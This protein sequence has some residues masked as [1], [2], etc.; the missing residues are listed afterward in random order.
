MMMNRLSWLLLLALAPL[1]CA[2][3]EEET[4]STTPPAQV[5]AAALKR[6]A[7]T[8]WTPPLPGTSMPL[9]NHMASISAVVE[10]KVKFILPAFTG[11]AAHEGK[12]I[13]P[14]DVIIQLDDTIAQANRAK[15]AAQ[16]KQAD[17]AVTAAQEELGRVKKLLMPM[18]GMQE[19]ALPL[20]NQVEL[21]KA[22]L[23]LQD[24][25][26][27]EK[28]AAAE[29]NALDQQLA[30]YKLRSPIA[31]RLGMIRAMPGQLL[32][33]GTT[34]AEVVSL[35]KIDVLCWVAPDTAAL[36][37]KKQSARIVMQDAANGDQPVASSG[38]V[39]FIDSQGQA[40]TGM[41]GV[42]VRFDNP[43]WRIRANA[44][45]RIQVC[46]KTK[47][48]ALACPEIALGTDEDPP[49]VIQVV[50]GK[51]KQG[52]AR[53]EARKLQA[54]IGVR[55]R[56]QGLVELV[57]LRDPESGKDVPL[58]DDMQFVVE[59][60]TGLETGDVV[61]LPKEEHEKEK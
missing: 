52:K 17:V 30:Y 26:A 7:L 2:R 59:G 32:T 19:S 45:L 50:E 51:D 34:V 13:K 1:A 61:E 14:D 12:E 58:R 16:K 6:A 44:I 22:R 11:E 38:N 20:S 55:D 53:L 28:A 27:K 35:E 42:K 39:V 43:D 60:G 25:E 57:G 21:Q 46:T 31:G 48:K 15:L 54:L 3:H 36:L 41:F 18:P 40:A 37:Q 23:A 56:D 47:D 33:A 8:Q 10:G 49:V 5:K 24:A 29:L 4:K 9:P